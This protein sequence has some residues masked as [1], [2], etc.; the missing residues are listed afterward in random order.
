MT[1]Q[2]GQQHA[3]FELQDVQVIQEINSIAYTWIHME[4]KLKLL[5]LENNDD[6]KVFMIGFRTPPGDSTGV[7]HIIEHSV[8]CGSD[9][10]PLKDP[11]LELAKGSMNTFINAMTSS[12]YTLYPVASQ[13]SKDFQ[14]LMDVYM[15]A[16]LH[17]V[18]KR[19]K[20]IFQQE[21]WHYEILDQQDPITIQGIVYNEMKGAYSS[22][23]AILDSHL[24]PSLYPHTPYR[25][26]SGGNPD[27]IPTLTYEDF[28]AFH[29]RFYHPSNGFIML[30][31]DG[32]MEEQLSFLQEKYLQY[33]TYQFVDSALPL[34]PSFNERK[35]VN[36]T[37]P[38]QDR[39]NLEEKTYFAL[40]FA[41]P[42]VV[43]SKTHLAW[44]VLT[45]ILLNSPTAPLKKALLD[46]GLGKD[47]FGGVTQS[48]HQPV[49]SI[50]SKHA[51]LRDQERFLSVIQ[52]T[53]AHIVAN[54]LDKKLV[55]SSLNHYEFLLK[56][57]DYHG[58]PKG[59]AYAFLMVMDSWLYDLKPTL[60]LAF[61]PGL[62]ALKQ[63]LSKP[64][65]EE[66]I[67]R[68]LMNNSHNSLLVGKPDL[69]MAEEK[70]SQL[71]KEMT[72]LKESLTVEAL[73]T[74]V[75]ESVNLK[76]YQAEEDSDEIRMKIPQL[77]LQDIRQSALWYPQTKETVQNVQ[78]LFQPIE[79]NGIAYL[80]VFF[81]I[82]QLTLEELPFVS[83]LTDLMGQ[84]DT[85]Q[86][87]YDVLSQEVDLH[88]G[89]IDF[90]TEIVNQF[91]SDTI[92]TP[93]FTVQTKFFP[94]YVTKA[95]SLVHEILTDTTWNQPKRIRELLQEYCSRFEMNLF[96]QGNRFA[97]RRVS[98]YFS[99]A[100]FIQE[101]LDGIGFYQWVL[102]WLPRLD[103]DFDLFMQTL[104]K[105]RTS[106]L[107]QAGRV[108]SV[109]GDSEMLSSLK[110][111]IQSLNQSW[112]AKQSGIA[113][114]EIPS[115]PVEEG[116]QTC[117]RVQYV[118]KGYNYKRK[119]HPYHG[120]YMVIDNLLSYDYLWSQIRVQGGAYGANSQINRNG[121]IGF[122]SY[123]DPHLRET[124]DVYRKAA[125][126]LRDFQASQR[127]INSYIIGSLSALDHPLTPSQQGD[128]AARYT[129][130][131]M[132]KAF[133]DQERE[134][135][136]RTTAKEIHAFAPILEECM[137]MPYTCVLGN[138][139][140]IDQEKELFN[141]LTKLAI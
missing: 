104:E 138:D 124:I 109:T 66:L 64:I 62:D 34:E 43:D 12:D 110:G 52:E 82:N 70:A 30:Y 140:K 95:L 74:L 1:K 65:F 73:Q 134:Q 60:H 67:Q 125:D 28:I 8:L 44:D 101:Q 128:R 31:G 85:K 32:N 13:N 107:Q 51:S 120:S 115:V 21:G 49:F 93:Y 24:L 89:G 5:Y 10:F 4:T 76:N 75:Q 3:G 83:L 46:A 103:K 54:G 59:L 48:L 117:A 116:I 77:S 56:E 136:F 127:V 53:L 11:F 61:Q 133:L 26:D 79:T 99:P 29:N 96:Y 17:P 86:H 33:Y 102:E 22:P 121:N 7:P 84:I 39:E 25:H 15:D 47:I 111:E 18:M 132:T 130:S 55:E 78:Y 106:L 72:A 2:I 90:N 131:G 40:N 105:V 20:K 6:N 123:R 50:I 98:H 94:R 97:M 112:P 42:P 38:A 108:V 19:E 27:F 118:A 58:L 23:E 91:D 71:E 114:W 137:K 37:Y 41:L 81:P 100:S 88:T 63:A 68:F 129:M 87:P 113:E 69:T 14:N 139:K 16:V 45:Y 36:F 122:V 141:K 135:I 35:T 80:K 126:F 119:G 9:K 92:F 57:A